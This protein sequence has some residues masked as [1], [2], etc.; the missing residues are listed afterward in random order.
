MPQPPVIVVVTT[1]QEPTRSLRLLDEAIG[2][3]GGGMIAVGDAKG[4]A[5]FELPTCRFLPLAEQ[6]RMELALAPRLPTG[7]YVRKNL[8]Y[9][10][11]MALGAACIYETDDDNAPVAAWRVRSRRT[12]A[13]T[14]A[15]RPWLNAYRLFSDRNIWPRGFPLDAVLDPASYD[16]AGTGEEHLV[17]APVQQDLADGDPDVDAIWRLTVGGD[18]TF[19]GGPSVALPA[20]TWC[21][22]NS[23]STWWWPPAYALMYLPSYCTFRMTDIWRG[24]IA[25]R[26]LWALG[27]R[28]VFHA[29]QVVQERNV[30]N[31][32]RDF[33]DEVPGYLGNRR[34]AAEL[35]ALDL[36]S[37]PDAVA[38]N[39]RRCYR[40]L[41]SAGYFPEEELELVEAWLKDAAAAGR[42]A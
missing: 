12:E 30:H 39:V 11:A 6:Q 22:F 41:V 14:V 40:T 5:Q 18:V 7:H 4:P 42:R 37:G 15:P 17:D 2:A 27:H 33:T 31:V 8:G 10:A 26:C 24:F 21:P 28:L 1:I 36:P 38:D 29:P 25:Q 19:R 3:I 16:R 9:L 35:D 20:G 34:F 13:C 23:Q 32:M